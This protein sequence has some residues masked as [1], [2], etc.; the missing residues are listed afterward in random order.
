MRLSPTSGVVL[1][2]YAASSVKQ[3][4]EVAPLLTTLLIVNV[5]LLQ[6]PILIILS[7]G[8]FRPISVVNYSLS[9]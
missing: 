2:I 5:D 6:I 7:K 1:C 4:S 3:F 9:K 8:N